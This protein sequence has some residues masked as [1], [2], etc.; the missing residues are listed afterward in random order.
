[1]PTFKVILEMR[2]NG[3]AAGSTSD[4]V[5]AETAHEAEQKLIA[6]WRAVEP[7]LT[8]APLLTVQTS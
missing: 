7:G 5:E 2:L 1:M 3:S 4:E 6:E 8:F